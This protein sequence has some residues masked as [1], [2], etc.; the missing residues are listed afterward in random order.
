[1]LVGSLIENSHAMPAE[2]R[3]TLAG[4]LALA[5]IPQARAAAVLFLLDPHSAVRR[6]AAAALAQ[7][8]TSLTP[9][10]IRRL[11]AIRN[12]RPENE[13]AECDGSSARRGRPGSIARNGR[14]AAR[15]N[16]CHQHRRL[17]SEG[18]LLLSLVGRKIRI[19]SILTKDGIEMLGAASRNRAAGSR[20]PWP[21][22]R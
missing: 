14:P 11:I 19:S 3:G 8:G 17:R 21:A 5:G 13:R 10:Y 18:F 16:S 6:A 9:K 22:P 2:A 20:R 15:D 4:A 7:V 12:W 1:M